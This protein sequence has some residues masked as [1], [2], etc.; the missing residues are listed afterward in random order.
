M[1]IRHYAAYGLIVAVTSAWLHGY[2]PLHSEPGGGVDL[3]FV[4]PAVL[5]VLAAVLIGWV[6]QRLSRRTALRQQPPVPHA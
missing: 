4:L 5:T 1:S 2:L 3:A 6:R